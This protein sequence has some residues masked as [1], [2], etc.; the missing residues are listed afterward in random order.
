MAN[1]KAGGLGATEN[2]QNCLKVM[3]A[4]YDIM[5][6]I[7]ISYQFPASIED[8]NLSYDIKSMQEIQFPRDTVEKRSGT[9]I[10]LA[11]L[12]AAMLHSIGI[13][14]YLVVTEDH[15]F[16][17]AH[18]PGGNIAAV[19]ATGVGDGYN[20][21]MTFDQAIK[22]GA[23][24]WETLNKSGRFVV[25]DV[26]KMWAAGIANPELPSLPADILDR[27]NI[28]KLVD[29]PAA[30]A[31]PAEVQVPGQEKAPA[32]QIPGIL[33]V[34][35]PAAPNPAPAAVAGIVGRW[36][37]TVPVNGQ[38][39]TGH[40]EI[41]DNGAQLQVTGSASY[42]L[43]GPDGGYHHFQ[44]RDE[45]VGGLSGQ[46]F[47]AQCDYVSTSMDGRQIPPQG[48][49]LYLNLILAPGGKSMQGQVINSMGYTMPISMQK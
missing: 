1:K 22:S 9:C 46:T 40:I 38:P 15:C 12:Y 49:P 41:K 31:M 19:E 42:Q 10:D 48:L 25:V 33:P 6:T 20:K 29:T 45:C 36:T 18:T 11:I 4:L 2:E 16:P 30:Q 23:K 17:V 27:W 7:H 47:S 35:P 24:T 8:P 28:A 3:G 21:G 37:Y 34:Q 5:R 26:E 39:I 43:R 32:Q 44:E 13:R 14:P